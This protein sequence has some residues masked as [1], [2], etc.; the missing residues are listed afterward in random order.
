[1]IK[2]FFFHH[3]RCNTSEHKGKLIEK[4]K[5]RHLDRCMTDL[6]SMESVTVEI[7]NCAPYITTAAQDATTTF[8]YLLA[9]KLDDKSH[10]KSFAIAI[11]NAFKTVQK[12]AKQASDIQAK[13]ANVIS[14][15]MIY[16]ANKTMSD[17][18]KIMYRITAHVQIVYKEASLAGVYAFDAKMKLDEAGN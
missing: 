15:I 5:E 16:E 6:M 10:A 1:M 9:S 7:S 4:S 18:A 13:A 14:E 11:E 17:A 3:L 8:S 2:K 12:M